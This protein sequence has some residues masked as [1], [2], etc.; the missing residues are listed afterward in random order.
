MND[1][2]SILIQSSLGIALFFM[3]YQLFMKKDTFFMTN[4]YYL[5]STLCLALLLPF[6]DFS[7]LNAP[8]N[9][10]YAVLLEPVFITPEGIQ[11]SISEHTDIYRIG[12]AVYLTGVTILASRL[13]FQILQIFLLTRKYGVIKQQGIYFVFTD[14]NYLPFSFFNLVFMNREDINSPEAQKIIAHEKVH[15]RQAHSLDLLF[16]ELI[17]IVQWYNPFIWLYRHSIKTLHEYLA[18]EGV[19]HSGVDAKVYSALLFEQCTGIRVNDLANN[20]SKSLLKRRFIMMTKERTSRLARLKLLLVL[21]LALSMMLAISFSSDVMA[22]QEK[23]EVPPPPPPKESKVVKAEAM[24]PQ[25]EEVPIFTV[26]EEMPEYPGGMKAL[27][28]YLGENIKYPDEAKK[29]GISGTVYITYVVEKDGSV[30]NAKVLRGAS[31]ELDKEAVRVVSAMPKW[32]PGKQKGIPV[33][34]QY[35]LP[36]KFALDEKDS[37]E[38]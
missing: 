28:S 18:D 2:I 35:N 37:K 25:D 23:K 26:V 8:G 15:I 13:I 5:L 16:T 22:Q 9:K 30:S 31:P 34:V 21:P 27:Y 7:F 17:T 10:I 19:L 4:R 36:I 6:V 3:I 12:M 33:R 29:N 32:K 20:F 24:A 38:K 11:A 1:Y 14:R